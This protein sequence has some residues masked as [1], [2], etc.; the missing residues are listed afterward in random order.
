MSAD[1]TSRADLGHGSFVL[2][3]LSKSAGIIQA[4]GLTGRNK[5]KGTKA[6]YKATIERGQQLL[7]EGAM[8]V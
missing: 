3:D 6:P 7:M 4:L 5:K 2:L 1:R 8:L